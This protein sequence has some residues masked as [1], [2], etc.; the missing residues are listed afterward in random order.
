MII[1]YYA[2]FF[3]FVLPLPIKDQLLNI[4]LNQIGSS[5]FAKNFVIDIFFT[6]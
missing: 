3:C 6:H 4:F 1:K 2:I 5:G